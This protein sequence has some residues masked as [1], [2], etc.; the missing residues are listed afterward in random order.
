MV[1]V[2]VGLLKHIEKRLLG[3]G[4]TYRWVCVDYKP[5]KGQEKWLI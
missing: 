5:A 4:L 2:E 1:R 3:D